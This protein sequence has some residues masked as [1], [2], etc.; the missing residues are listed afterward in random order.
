MRIA[1]A[2]VFLA[3]AITATACA[4]EKSSAPRPPA[5]DD[6]VASCSPSVQH[7]EI[8]LP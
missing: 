8:A 2:L 4:H 7:P 6:A 5:C 3:S 1:I